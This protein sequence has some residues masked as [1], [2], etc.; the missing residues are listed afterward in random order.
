MSPAAQGRLFSTRQFAVFLTGLCCFI[1]LYSMQA[2]LPLLSDVFSASAADVAMVVT[3]GT[4]AVAIVAPFTGA[5]AD[6]IGRKRVII[7][8]MFI[9][10]VPTFMAA[11]STTLPELV[12]WRFAQGV[13][14][15]PIFVVIIAYIGEEW[16]RHEATTAAGV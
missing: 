13:I 7:A 2:I 9:L 11:M 14:L 15:P 5:A 4:L 8:A 10:T 1:N 3:A 6:V 16:P 12:F